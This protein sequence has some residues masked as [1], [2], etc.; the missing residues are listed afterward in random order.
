MTTK[1]GLVI[2][3]SRQFVSGL[4]LLFS[5]ASLV[6][7]FLVANNP[8][9]DSFMSFLQDHERIMTHGFLLPT[10]QSCMPALASVTSLLATVNLWLCSR[11]RDQVRDA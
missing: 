9:E 6:V 8:A 7:G 3:N 4:L 5:L 1:T 11:R 10:V 2:L